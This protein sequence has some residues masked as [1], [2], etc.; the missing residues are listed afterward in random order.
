MAAPVAELVINLDGRLVAANAQARSMFSITENDLGEPFSSLDVSVRPLELRDH[1]ERVY[2]E[3]QPVVIHDVRMSGPDGKVRFLE[4][5]IVRLRDRLGNDLGAAI[6]YADVS[7]I[8]RARV[9]LE[10]LSSELKRSNEELRS[11][12]I[13]LEASNEELQSTNEE[14]ET[15]NEELQSANEEL[16]TMNEELRSAN[17]ELETMNEELLRQATEIEESKRFVAATLDSLGGGVAVLSKDLDVMI[18]NEAAR[19]LFGLREDE[20]R[21]RSFLALDIGLPVGEIGPLL[22]ALVSEDS[23]DDDATHTPAEAKVVELDAVDRRGRP[24]RCRVTVRRFNEQSPEPDAELIVF[25]DRI[26]TEP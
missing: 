24:M 16:E 8:G 23:A 14:L 12:N 6:T 22:H 26:A 7:E 9:G 13:R 19:D 2:Q 17:E 21:G 20:A 18:W 11:V 1:I 4:V 10:A 15:T 25:I 3:F 5:T